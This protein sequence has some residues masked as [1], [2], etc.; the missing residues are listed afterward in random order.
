MKLF[1]LI[2]TRNNSVLVTEHQSISR[3]KETNN[4]PIL[5]SYPTHIVSR[6]GRRPPGAKYIRISSQALDRDHMG[7]KLHRVFHQK[8]KRKLHRVTNPAQT[9][10]SYGT[11]L[12]QIVK[13][14]NAAAT[15]QHIKK[16]GT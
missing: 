16:Q 5:P 13:V 11:W 2:N 14:W 4:T 8:K 10:S 12:K 3:N 6:G 9:L 15:N 1:I 7:R